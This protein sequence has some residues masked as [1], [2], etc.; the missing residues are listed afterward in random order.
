MS[1]RTSPNTES[2]RRYVRTPD[3]A[4]RLGCAAQTLERWRIEG[5]GPP[6]VKLSPKIVVYDLVDLDSW[7]DAR[8]VSSTSEAPTP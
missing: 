1:I 4:A 3:A 2:N 7:A 5:G 6:F 8:K